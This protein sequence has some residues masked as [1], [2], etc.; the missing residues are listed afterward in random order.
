[1]QMTPFFSIVI[2]CCN[3]ERYV[4]GCLD[5]I[6]AQDFTD[7]ECLV[8]VEE[9]RDGTEQA[10]RAYADRDPR[11]SVFTGPRSGSPSTPRNKCLEH[12]RGGYVVFVDA[13]DAIAAGSLARL[14]DKISSRSGADLY[15]CAIRVHDESS[16][17]DFVHDNY[18][19]DTPAELSGHEAIRLLASLRRQPSPMAQ[20]TICRREFLEREGLRFFP[21]LQQEDSEFLPRSLY[22]AKRV[23]PLHEPFYIYVKGRED[24][25]SS[26][27]VR[28][29]SVLLGSFAKVYK[30]LLGFFAEVS[31]ESDFDA[32]VAAA[33]AETWIGD[34]LLRW[35]DPLQAG[36]TPRTVRFETLRTMFADGFGD[37]S[38]LLPFA[39]SRKRILMKIVRLAVERRLPAALADLLL[40]RVYFPLVNG[41]RGA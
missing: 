14:H 12:A 11:F 25:I 32:A 38:L 31:R 40:M 35:F 26:V 4:R 36:G 6:I 9:S 37:L 23:V 1:M 39:S 20:M 15:P 27:A 2:P 3:V 7:W 13:D 17:R 16:K 28:D 41:R 22:R 29:R 34:I 30:S 33:W 21:G 24:A 8:C 10:V 19:E 5:S 18:P